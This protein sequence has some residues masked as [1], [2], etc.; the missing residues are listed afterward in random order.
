MTAKKKKLERIPSG[1]IKI[2]PYATELVRQSEMQP[3]I[4]Y[5][6]ALLQGEREAILEAYKRIKILPLDKRYIYRVSEALNWGFADFDS[7]NLV[8]DLR[9]LSETE[10]KQIVDKFPSRAIQFCFLLTTVFGSVQMEEMMLQAISE[11]KSVEHL[12]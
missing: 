4:D 6:V 11:A 5:Y 7:E 8:C 10:T 1:M 2:D 9:C 12:L 3:Y